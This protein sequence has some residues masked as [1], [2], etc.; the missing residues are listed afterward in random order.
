MRYAGTVEQILRAAGHPLPADIVAERALDDLAY[1][2]KAPTRQQQLNS[3]T[4][5]LASILTRYQ[6]TKPSS[7]RIF[8]RKQGP[9]PRTGRLVYLYGLLEWQTT[10][11]NTSQPPPVRRITIP[12]TGKIKERIELLERSG[13]Y[14]SAPEAVQAVLAWG[15]EAKDKELN[16]LEEWIN[17]I[18][19]IRL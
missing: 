18:K 12:L 2:S 19:R 6:P 4:G 17:E 14:N 15:V 7:E 16:E 10:N 9:H 13:K 3:L 5:A 1:P 11:P 8:Y